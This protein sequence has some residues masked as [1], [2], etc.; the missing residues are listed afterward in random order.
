MEQLKT[1]IVNY[2]RG[3]YAIDQQMVRAFLIVGSKSALLLDTGAV[4]V[5]I[6]KYIEQITGLPVTVILTHGDADHTGNLMA[7]NT[8]Y[9]NENDHAAVLS[10]E[11]GKDVR[12]LS[13]SEGDA[14]DIGGRVLK[15][16]LTPGHTAGSVCL[17]DEEN[18]ILFAGDTVSYGPVFMFGAGRSMT[19]YLESLRRLEKLSIDGVFKTVYCCHGACP[20][21][22][23]AVEELK[24]CAEGV[25]NHTIS[26]VPAPMPGPADD[27]P[28]LCKYG[29][30]MLLVD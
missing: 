29:K 28:L 14:F 20:I 23:D 4:C 6:K 30:C 17:L 16:L 1:A 7:Y 22:A 24:S 9:C 5:D 13:L 8:A 15:T 3:I 10:H 12:L 18:G 25:L 11:S 19:D 2:G 27:K 21:P 26:G